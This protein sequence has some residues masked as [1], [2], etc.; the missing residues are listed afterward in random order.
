MGMPTTLVLGRHGLSDGNLAVEAAKAGDHSYYTDAF[1]TTPGRMWR[2]APLGREQ[3]AVAGAW[4]DANVAPRFDRYWCSPFVRTRETAGHMALPGANWRYNR[5]FRERDWGDIGSLPREQFETRPEYALNAAM[6]RL[7]PLYWVPAGGES[8]AHVAEDRVR[9]ILSTMHR[10]CDRQTV[11][12]ITHGE[13]MWAFRL[14]LER[15]DDDT[16]TALDADP[17]EK[18]HNCCQLIYTRQN[19]DPSASRRFLPWGVRP[20]RLAPRLTWRRR[21]HP[22]DRGDGVLEMVVSDWVEFDQRTYS[23]DE[24][25]ASVADV[26]SLVPDTV[27]GPHRTAV[28]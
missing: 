14:V 5:A 23:N 16:F 20:R 1:T 26:P 27:S 4:V 22:A 21:A 12:A 18:I 11:I 17:A 19:P 6:K 3:A 15:L 10:E 9:N 24:L 7:D 13:L 28:R 2:L 25:L 8:I